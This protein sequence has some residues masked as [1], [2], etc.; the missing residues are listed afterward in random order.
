MNAAPTETA[1]DYKDFVHTGPGTLAGRYLRQFWQPVYV[2]DEL[3]GGRAKPIRIMGE[4]LTLYRG[5]A[6]SSSP[7]QSSP[8]E[9]GGG[10][11]HLLAFRCAHRGTQL[12]TGWVE[13]DEL[14]CLYHGWKYDGSGQCVEQPAEP[15][16][17]CGRIKIRGYPTR[18]YLG[19]VFAYL[20]EGEPPPLPRYELFHQEGVLSIGTEHLACNFFNRMDNSTDPVHTKFVHR[21]PDYARYGLVGI[22]TIWADEQPWGI[23]TYIKWPEWHEDEIDV[24]H[25]LMPNILLNRIDRGIHI[26]WRVPVDDVSSMVFNVAITPPGG[27]RRGGRA[28]EAST[29]SSHEWGAA[30]LQGKASVQD[31][32]GQEGVGSRER[33]NLQDYVAQVGQGT[34]V[35]HRH[36]RLG[37]TDVGILLLRKIWARELRAFSEQRSLTQW[38]AARAGVAEWGTGAVYAHEARARI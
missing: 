16:P 36:E 26:A 7:P 20:G 8:A 28:A 4:D 29:F 24:H 15:E 21:W 38:A 35:D 37:Q 6:S 3:T 18:E 32:L 25:V 13:G 12:S 30:V 33:F 22:P 9:E 1:A 14:R 34:V 5:E 19:L 31:A 10:K 2:A 23:S 27:E 11:P 17:F